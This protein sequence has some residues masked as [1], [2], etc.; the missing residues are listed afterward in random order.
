MYIH[1]ECTFGDVRSSPSIL[2]QKRKFTYFSVFKR[3]CLGSHEFRL[4][5]LVVYSLIINFFFVFGPVVVRRKSSV[6]SLVKITVKV[7][8]LVKNT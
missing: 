4:E 5:S 8:E 6:V 7:K 2:G 1:F 3:R